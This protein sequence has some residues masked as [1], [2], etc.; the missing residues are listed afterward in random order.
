MDSDDLDGNFIADGIENGDGVGN[1]SLEYV[2][3]ID[4]QFGLEESLKK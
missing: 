2:D 3:N 1:G 4:N